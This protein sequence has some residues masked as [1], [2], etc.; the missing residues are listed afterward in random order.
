MISASYKDTEPDL[1]PILFMLIHGSD[2][3]FSATAISVSMLF[4]A[5]GLKHFR[6]KKKNR[7]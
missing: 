1:D 3:I 4:T 5:P 7:L 6:S 2:L